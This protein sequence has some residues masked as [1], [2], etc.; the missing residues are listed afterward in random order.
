MQHLK[1][2]QHPEVQA[3][4]ADIELMLARRQMDLPLI[5]CFAAERGDDVLLFQ[6]LKRG[7]DPNELSRNGR[8]ALVRLFFCILAMC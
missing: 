8:T 5:L 2:Y 4:S 1:E 7:S 3:I 6:L